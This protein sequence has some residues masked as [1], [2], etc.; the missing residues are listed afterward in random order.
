MRLLCRATEWMFCCVSPDLSTQDKRLTY[1]LIPTA[2]RVMLHFGAEPRLPRPLALRMRNQLFGP[3]HQFAEPKTESS[4][5]S[6]CD[7]DSHVH[8]AQFD[9]ADICAV[10]TSAL[11]EVFLGKTEFLPRQTDRPAKGES[12]ESCCPGHPILLVF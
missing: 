11:C 1:R 2:P 8:L 9:R 12:R 4:G 5:Q 3:T 10:H 7:F 6:V